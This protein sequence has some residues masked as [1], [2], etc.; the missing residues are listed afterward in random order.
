MKLDEV[1]QRIRQIISDRQEPFLPPYWDDGA[2]PLS[3]DAVDEIIMAVEALD[4]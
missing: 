3:D 4:K 1:R 2:A